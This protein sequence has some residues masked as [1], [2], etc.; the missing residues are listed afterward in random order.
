M[1][2]ECP[3]C[4]VAMLPPNKI[5]KGSCGHVMCGNCAVSLQSVFVYCPSPK[6][7][8]KMTEENLFRDFVAEWVAENTVQRN[9]EIPPPLPESRRSLSGQLMRPLVPFRF[10]SDDEMEPDDNM[11][12]IEIEDEDELDPVDT[13]QVMLDAEDYAAFSY[14]SDSD[15]SDIEDIGSLFD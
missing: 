1:M 13:L 15:D 6:C 4:D 12:E 3:V 7:M 14:S 11:V 5:F 8:M 2:L 10:G 9:K